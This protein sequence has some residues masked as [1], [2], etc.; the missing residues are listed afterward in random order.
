[1]VLAASLALVVAVNAV[2]P[3]L[4]SG[5]GKKTDEAKGGAA[6]CDRNQYQSFT[7]K[8]DN[9]KSEE[10]CIEVLGNSDVWSRE[11]K[12]RYERGGYDVLMK[13]LE[14]EKELCDFFTGDLGITCTATYKDGC[15]E[16]K[17]NSGF[18]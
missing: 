17:K 6:N 5:E 12:S 2:T 16:T 3:M 18:Q 13:S 14:E 7:L 11:K 15:T 1:M 8:Y 4:H 9:Q 10:T